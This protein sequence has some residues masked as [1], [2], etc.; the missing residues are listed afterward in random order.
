[1]AVFKEHKLSVNYDMVKECKKIEDCFELFGVMPGG[2][3]VDYYGMYYLKCSLPE[4]EEWFDN[5]EQRELINAGF[6]QVDIDLFNAAKKCDIEQVKVL[7]QQGADPTV[8]LYNESAESNLTN[9]LLDDIS[10]N[11]W[12]YKEYYEVG[13]L[14]A[15]PDDDYTRSMLCVLF[16]MASSAYL[17]RIMKGYGY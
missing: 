5:E 1:M 8:D 14:T 9:T 7:L 12:F 17:L 6:R 2:F 3:K 15:K 16:D 13:S 4:D 11:L 10:V